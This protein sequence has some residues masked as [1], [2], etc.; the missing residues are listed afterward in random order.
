MATPKLKH[1]VSIITSSLSEKKIPHALIGAMA[2]SCY[3][4]PRFTADM[5]FLS[6]ET[7]RK[8][9]LAIMKRLGY[10]CFQDEGSFAQFD[11]ELGVYGKVDFMFVQT[12]EG[13]EIIA[14]AVD[15]KDEV[16]GVVPVVQPTDY[17]ILKLMAIAN[18]R[19][20][21]THDMADLEILFKSVAAGFLNPAFDPINVD[22][23]Q[24]FADR[25]HVSEHLMP[26]L[27]LFDKK[28]LI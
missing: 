2:L 24:I 10:E 25:F 6:D 4:M 28:S 11:S 13:L 8:T 16:M 21:M 22:Q 18:N 23:L 26:L 1:V 17:A 14:S 19:D 27:A 7:H 3:G 12:P 9:I 5:D 15:I 20:R